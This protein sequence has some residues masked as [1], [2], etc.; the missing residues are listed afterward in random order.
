MR[1]ARDISGE[2]SQG[3]PEPMGLQTSSDGIVGTRSASRRPERVAGGPAGGETEAMHL[4]GSGSCPSRSEGV[5]PRV[6]QR[7]GALRL[8][9]SA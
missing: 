1:F 7:D 4:D 5:K 2:L 6:E 3:R 9:M 8:G